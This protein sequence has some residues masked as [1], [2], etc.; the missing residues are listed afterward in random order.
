RAEGVRI[1]K[2][3]RHSRK[4]RR[5]AI[6]AN[7]FTIIVRDFDDPA[8]AVPPALARVSKQGF[9]NF[10]GTQ[11]FGNAGSNIDLAA[12]WFSGAIRLRGDKR[13]MALSA[14]RS[15]IFNAVLDKRVQ[16]DSWLTC[17]HG[18]ALNPEGRGGFF[19][20]DS[21]DED[22]RTRI[23]NGQLHLT[24]P[25]WGSGPFLTGATIADFEAGVAGQFANLRDGLEG[26]R[27]RHQR[28]ALRAMPRELCWEQ[29]DNTL[30]LSF[31][32]GSGVYATSLLSAIL[33]TDETRAQR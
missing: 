6:A 26:S 21:P 31:A 25:L 3:I 4:L 16:N 28:R 24:G 7:E 22:I 12:R 1:L 2:S 20:C 30:H 17:Q 8:D 32:L 33:N 23:A 27:M 10:F 5:G 9:P 14:A 13:S 19:L 29:R 18:E 15:L 11:R